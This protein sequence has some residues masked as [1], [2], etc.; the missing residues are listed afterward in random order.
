MAEHRD[1]QG[2]RRRADKLRFIGWANLLV[3]VGAGLFIDFGD[4][5]LRWSAAM[6]WSALLLYVCYARAARMDRQGPISRA[7]SRQR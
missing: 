7:S 4:A 1:Q 6:A 5:A 2:L 3:C